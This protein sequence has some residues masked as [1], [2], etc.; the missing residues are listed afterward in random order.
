MN[1][2]DNV[3]RISVGIDRLVRRT[4]ASGKARRGR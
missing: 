4:S 2:F 1:T 3:S